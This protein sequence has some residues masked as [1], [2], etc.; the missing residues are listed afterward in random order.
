MLL[1]ARRT[2]INKLKKA[3]F[4]DRAIAQLTGHRSIKS[5]DSYNNLSFHEQESLSLALSDVKSEQQAAASAVEEENPPKVVASDPD[6][7]SI[8]PQSFVNIPLLK[9]CN[10]TFNFNVQNTH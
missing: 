2:C 10:V 7:A 6:Q 9:E 8:T 4:E 1:S 5:L 3:G